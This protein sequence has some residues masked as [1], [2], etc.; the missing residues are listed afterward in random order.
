MEG[1]LPGD[2]GIQRRMHKISRSGVGLRMVVR[3]ILGR[4]QSFDGIHQQRPRHV[5]QCVINVHDAFLCLLV[6][7][8]VVQLLRTTGGHCVK[9][10]RKTP[11]TVFVGVV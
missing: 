8:G 11:P 9:I 6:D 3:L 10:S 7:H 5:A 2:V 1:T 4:S